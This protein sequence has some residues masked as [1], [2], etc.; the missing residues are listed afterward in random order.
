MYNAH[1]SPGTGLKYRLYTHLC[2]FKEGRV[3]CILAISPLF[4]DIILHCMYDDSGE[5]SRGNVDITTK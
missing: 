3:F 1:V 2:L 5:C 4:C